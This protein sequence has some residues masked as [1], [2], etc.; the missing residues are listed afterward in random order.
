MWLSLDKKL[1][2]ILII[3]F[4]LLFDL[5]SLQLG[6]GNKENQ[7]FP[8][9]IMENVKQAS[10]SFSYSMIIKNDNTLWATGNNRYGQFGN[11]KIIKTDDFTFIM[12][13]VKSV[14]TS[15]D[16]SL[17]IKLDDSLWISGLYPVQINEKGKVVWK[18]TDKYILLAENV[19]KVVSGRRHIIFLKQD[20]TLWGIGDNSFGQLGL[21]AIKGTI[22]AV[23]ISDNVQNMYASNNYSYYINH[24]CLYL[25]GQKTFFYDKQGKEI[26]STK[27]IKVY[28]DV[29][30]VSTG[31]IL[32]SDGS[33]YGFG[34][35]CYGAL[36]LGRKGG[37]AEK[38][39][40]IL[41]EV[42][43]ISSNHEHSLMILKNGVLMSCGGGSSLNYGSIGNGT[44]TAAYQPEKIMENVKDCSVGEY[45]SLIIKDDNSLWG[46]GLNT[47][48]EDGLGL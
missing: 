18:R 8:V 45:F 24:N 25:A 42:E 28:E 23:K 11:N 15:V 30:S 47:D 21:G 20:E 43:K 4:F 40:F 29:I 19:K 33:L 41:N 48:E 27:F 36:G 31:L 13:N 17:I 9:K 39:S 37:K 14:E 32:Q 6:N 1:V 10:A 5:V 16:F 44:K 26:V 38:I 3:R 12:E 7:L 46:F 35:G 22:E 2:L 34:Y